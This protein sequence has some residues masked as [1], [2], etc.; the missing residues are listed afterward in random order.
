MLTDLREIIKH[1][2][3]KLSDIF[4]NFDSHKSGVLAIADFTK[5]IRVIAPKISD[6][7]IQGL[8]AS[9]DEDGNGTI[10]F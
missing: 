10:D 7:E 1:N 8:F 4:N 3:I 2:N 5:L 9:F 6:N